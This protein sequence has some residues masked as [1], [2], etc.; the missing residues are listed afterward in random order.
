MPSSI[1]DKSQPIWRSVAWA[2]AVYVATLLIIAMRISGITDNDGIKRDALENVGKNAKTG[3]VYSL[4]HAD[5]EH[6]VSIARGGYSYDPKSRSEVAFFPVFPFTGRAIAAVTCLTIQNGLLLAAHAYLLG[7]F[8]LLALYARQRCGDPSTDAAGYALLAFGLFPPTFFFRMLYSESSFLFLAILAML[9][10]QRRWP[11][12]VTAMIVGLAT[13]TRPV[14][15][16]LV[17]VFC[18]NLWQQSASWRGLAF[19]SV[20]LVPVAMCGLIAY[21]L[22][23]Y[24]AF[25]EPLAFAKTQEHWTV[26]K[27]VP[28]EEK[29]LAILSHEPIWS[30]Y[31]PSSEACWQRTQPEPRAWDNLALANPIYFLLA[32]GLVILGA[33]KRWLDANETVLA[34]ILILIPYLTRSFEMGTLSQGRFVAAAFPIYLVLGRLLGRIPAPCAALL[35]CLSALLMATYAADFVAGYFLI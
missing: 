7:A 17:P 15:V 14:G 29:A 34:A 3:W 12:A 4:A 20:L 35:A 25:G 19:R 27:P 21:M 28:L 30:V 13:A 8:V 2:V 5:G 23:Q 16:A 10:M 22:Y 9:A 26:R 18:M 6:F 31:V 33:W 32:V 1:P 24:A 11:M